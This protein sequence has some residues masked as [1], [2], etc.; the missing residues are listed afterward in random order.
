MLVKNPCTR[1]VMIG[2]FFRFWQMTVISFYCVSYFNYYNNQAL[3]GILNG[4]VILCGGLTSSLVVGK[5]SDKYEKVNLRTKSYFAAGLSA[6]GVPL[7]AVLFMFHFN[8]YFSLTILFFEN[9]L[10]E[11]WMAPCI[12]MI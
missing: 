3:F 11:G 6:M 4:A 2:G 10:C 1:W 12:A 5:L 9:L 8:F 7:F